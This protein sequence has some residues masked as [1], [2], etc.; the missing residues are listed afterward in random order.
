MTSIDFY[1]RV[2][3][4]IG[5]AARLVGKAFAQHG[6][7]RVLTPDAEATAALD[8][9]LWM[10][11]AVG[12]LPH[13]TLSAPLASDTPIIVDHAVEHAG[14]AEVLINLASTPPPFFARFERLAEIV[15]C[16]EASANAGRERYRFYRE[17]GYELRVHSMT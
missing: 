14:P 7:V 16:D 12:F 15:S 8:R 4:P 5:I 1:T 17:R 6:H 9:L 10:Q 13:C 2:D 11:P 3:D